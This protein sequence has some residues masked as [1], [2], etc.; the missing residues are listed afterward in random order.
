VEDPK[1]GG[2]VFLSE[3]IKVYRDSRN[4]YIPTTGEINQLRS[5]LLSKIFDPLPSAMLQNT[6]KV[7]A[8]VRFGKT[9]VAGEGEDIQIRIERASPAAFEARRQELLLD[10]NSKREF[11]KTIALLVSLPEEID[12]LL[13]DAKRSDFILGSIPERDADKDVAQFL[14]SERAL[15]TR[16]QEKAQ[17][18]IAKALFD[19]GVF[20]FRGGPKPV[21]EDSSTLE[22][23]CRKAVE[24]AAK[25]V[26]HKFHLVPIRP[27]TDLAAKFLEI[28]R[29]ERMPAERDPLKFVAKTG[30]HH[31]VQI[32]QDA[33]AEAR[34]AFQER[35]DA[36]GSGRLLG[37]AIQ[38]D[39]ADAPYGWTKDATR[40]VFAALFRASE[41]QLH[42][43]EGIVTTVGPKAV[44]AFKSSVAFNRIG[45]SL[46]NSKPPL[47]ALDRA[48]RRLEDLFAVEVL[49][50]EEHISRA[51]R[52]HVPSVI[53]DVS[54]LPDRLRLLRL[55]GTERAQTLLQTCADLL[56]EDASGATTVLGANECQLQSDVV[57]AQTVA[58]ALSDDGEEL[59]RDAHKLVSSV[60]ELGE[61]FPKES[62][63]LLPPAV[64]ET[65]VEIL[66]S[67][68]FFERI[69]DLRT[70]MAVALTKIRQRYIELRDEYGDAVQQARNELE[71]TGDWLKLTPEDR[72]EI[73]SRL[74]SAD[75]PDQPRS[76]REFVDL[77]LLMTRRTGLPA[78]LQLLRGEVALRTPGELIEEEEQM[79]PGTTSAVSIS[80]SDLEL[81]ESIS[82]AEELD[83]WIQ[84]LRTR[85]LTLLS[86][87]S[88]IRFGK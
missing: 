41:I 9:P 51:V 79:Q 63:G 56:K 11:E 76:G 33:L 27:P 39:F 66:N 36:T 1:A 59:V 6:K 61:L 31:T 19:S 86:E 29:L 12:D 52:T 32:S 85:L 15:L 69:S 48:A 62:E 50:L 70:A 46:R 57:W 10:T 72:Q 26:F 5:D 20:I 45:L 24:A 14:R 83:S 82:T 88:T 73:A 37:K 18:L 4:K 3:G 55:Q 53:E 74:L 2:Y 40:Y 75:V 67:K 38:D 71:D 17:R 54:S 25:Q 21:K 65:I 16:C 80:P 58:K 84:H 44:E 22:T 34:R 68:T 78:Q 23:A 7:T 64:R 81:P 8:G 49:P 87:Y 13:V 28:E 30:A 42:T 47:D 35:L 43:G 60:S 77:Q